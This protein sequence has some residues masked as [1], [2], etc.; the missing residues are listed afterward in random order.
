MR[1]RGA[2]LWRSLS[3]SDRARLIAVQIAR[4]S[5][6]EWQHVRRA[7]QEDSARRRRFWEVRQRAV[8]YIMARRLAKRR[9]AA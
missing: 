4:E 7:L 9:A 1:F 5:D 6:P 2:A 8:R 3:G